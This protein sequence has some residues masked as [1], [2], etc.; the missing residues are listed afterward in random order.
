MRARLQTQLFG[1]YFGSLSAHSYGDEL[2]NEPKSVH[3][4][5][6]FRFAPLL[7]QPPDMLAGAGGLFLAGAF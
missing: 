3:K 2:S 6:D 7:G 4:L 1:A 5:L